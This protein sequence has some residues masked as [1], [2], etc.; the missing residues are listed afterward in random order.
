MTNS[1]KRTAAILTALV[2][3]AASLTLITSTQADAFGSRFR[4]KSKTP[5]ITEIAVSN[6]NF[7]TLV[8]ALECTN[9]DRIVSSRFVRLTVFAPT[10][11]AF[12]KL[13]LDESNICDAFDKRTLRNIL[14]YHTT[15]GKKDSS[16]VLNR[17]SL[18][19][20]NW[21]RA[22]IDAS[23]PSIAGAEINTD[24]IDIKASNGIIHVVNDVL[25]P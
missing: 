14:L 17:N 4:D 2:I 20:L 3:A 10:D 18:R 19:M 8:A 9:L 24:L 16:I 13:S 1:L 7:N 25:L 5:N 11:A 12:E 21:Q 23:V 15:W 6:G 22:S